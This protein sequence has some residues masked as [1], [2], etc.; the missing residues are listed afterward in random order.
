MLTLSIVARVLPSSRTV[1]FF[2]TVFTF[3]MS[4][5]IVRFL[6]AVARRAVQGGRWSTHE[7]TG[8]GV[9]VDV[10]TIFT[11]AMSLRKVKL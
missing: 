6:D 8:S 7:K 9:T 4:L 1:A 11:F 5:R 2:M 3:A 10:V